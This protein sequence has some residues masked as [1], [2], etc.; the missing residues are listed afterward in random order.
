MPLRTFFP[1]RER[2]ARAHLLS[3]SA[4]SLLF[5]G[6]LALASAVGLARTPFV[7]ASTPAFAEVAF[8]P[9]RCA[10]ADTVEIVAKRERPA[11][12]PSLLAPPPPLLSYNFYRERVPVPVGVLLR[13]HTYERTRF[14]C[15]VQGADLGACLAT[16]VSSLGLVTGLWGE[17]TAAYMMGAGAVLGAIW[18]GTT[19]A[20][21]TGI[22]IGARLDDQHADIERHRSRP[23]AR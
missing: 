12:A 4:M 16:N 11:P 9:E 13:P 2:R 7:G 18:G 1:G 8:P 17:K 3:R 6:V 22:S 20:N 21:R 14:A 23:E 10:V 15:A 19:T 5:V